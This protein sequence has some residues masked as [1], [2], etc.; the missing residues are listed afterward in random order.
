VVDAAV[1][2]FGMIVVAIIRT[3][4]CLVADIVNSIVRTSVAVLS[5]GN[6]AGV[7]MDST[8]R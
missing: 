2:A 4:V 3:N 5:E 6:A 7:D 8:R 1:V